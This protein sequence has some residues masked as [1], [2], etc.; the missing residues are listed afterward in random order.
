MGT[1]HLW[2]I[3]P[4]TVVTNTGK[5]DLVRSRA[6]AEI[7]EEDLPAHL[8]TGGPSSDFCYPRTRLVIVNRLN[9]QAKLKKIA[10]KGGR[11]DGEFAATK[12]TSLDDLYDVA[13]H[14]WYLP[15]GFAAVNRLPP[16]YLLRLMA[17]ETVWKSAKRRED[18]QS[19]VMSILTKV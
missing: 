15:A 6:V 12:L 7:K 4:L 8:L 2:P 14:S 18:I 11:D 16:E 17:P 3:D 19:A 1:H 13:M 5:S 10:L 9:D